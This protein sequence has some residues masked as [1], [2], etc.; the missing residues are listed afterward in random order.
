LIT[1]FL[2][3]VAVGISGAGA[4]LITLIHRSSK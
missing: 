1:L 3:G 4:V 2:L